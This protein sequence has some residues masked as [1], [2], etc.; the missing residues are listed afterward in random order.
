APAANIDLVLAK[1][2]SNTDLV[3]A[4]RFAVENDLG[5][6]ISQSFGE[7]ES[8]VSTTNLNDEHAVFAEAT[9]KHITLLASSGDEGA[10]QQTCD[11]NS[12]TQAASWPASDPLVT[13][14]GATELFAAFDCN[15]A[16][17]CPANHP[18]PGTYDHEV[19]LNEPPTFTPGNFSTGGGFSVR[20]TRP[21][22]QEG[23]NA[24]PASQR[25]VPDIAYSGSINHGVLVA[26]QIC[27]L[28]SS[29]IPFFIFGGTSV[30]SPNWAGLVTLANQL[31]GRRLGFI[32]TAI[33]RIGRSQA[34]NHVSDHDITVG[35]NSVIEPDANGNPVSVTG[36]NA[37][38][39]WDAATGWGTPKADVLV[40]L[41]VAVTIISYGDV[42]IR[43]S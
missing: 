33:Y 24:I 2:N 28:S 9:R 1:S 27:D 35:N 41:L 19:A 10:A 20:F 7:N 31:A 32:N 38:T 25:G 15:T 30:G 40:P 18:T 5:D 17:P 34:L 26:C 6:V 3:S 4:T 8:C 43:T 36:F 23:V 14:V 29:T 22:Y 13:A 21:A 12:W 16:N 39:G 42:A 37:T 11:G